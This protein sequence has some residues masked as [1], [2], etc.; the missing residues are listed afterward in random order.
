MTRR[1]SE[2]HVSEALAVGEKIAACFGVDDFRCLSTRPLRAAELA[3]GHFS[4]LYEENSPPVI[5]PADDAFLVMLYLIDVEHQDIWPDR[6]P[7]PFKIYPKGS[8]CL[9]SLKEGA[10]IAVRGR[11]EALAFHIPISH[12]AELAE[13]IG[14]QRV[15]SLKTCRGMEDQ[16]IRD[17]GAALMPV[18]DMPEDDMKATLLAHV[19]LAFNAHI[20]HRY[21]LS[22]QPTLS[23]NKCLTAHSR[24]GYTIAQVAAACGF[25]T[26]LEFA[27]TFEAATG[28]T[29]LQWRSRYRH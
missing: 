3:I 7:A 18:F 13:E 1:T 10:S 8:I 9:I 19:G 26:E 15:A 21:G 27:T 22:P 4:H 6:P 29:P 24:T 20:V 17:L 5:L 25:E 12:L 23:A 16:I 11:F 28:S 2:T 14:E